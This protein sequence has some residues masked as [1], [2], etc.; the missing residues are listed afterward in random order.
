MDD[1]RLLQA[2][3]LDD[4][5]RVVRV[6]AAHPSGTTELVS[7]A[8]RG[9]H[10]RKRIP[11][12]L[13]NRQAWEALGKVRDQR[14]PRVEL[15]YELPDALVVVCQYVVGTTVA[16]LLSRQTRL[17]AHEAAG[18]ALGVC[19]AASALHAQG[20]VHRDIAPGNVVIAPNILGDS[21]SNRTYLI[22]LG[23]A[24]VRSDDVAAH[25]TTTLG[26]RGFSAPEQ[27]GF[28]QTDARSDVYSIGRLLLCLLLGRTSDEVSLD[29]AALSHDAVPARLRPIIERACAFEPSA[30]YQSAADMA[31][32]LE[33]AEVALG[34]T[35]VSQGGGGYRVA[36]PALGV[37]DVARRSN[38]SSSVG[39]AD[40]GLWSRLGYAQAWAT[41]GL[42]R[43]SLG[44]AS[45]V[46]ALCLGLTF[47]SAAFDSSK[48]TRPTDPAYFLAA[49]LIG[50]ACS[51]IA[52]NELCLFFLRGGRY[53]DVPN[54][55]KL[56][57]RVLLIDAAAMVLLMMLAAMISGV[58]DGLIKNFTAG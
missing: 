25:D 27:Y 3:E 30:R 42:I 13:A 56:L 40:A 37:E 14:V 49:G 11:H 43:Q 33:E 34:G 36:M 55:K 51:L 24:R 32:D 17:E 16:E 15:I 54:R 19:R 4:S 48:F 28:A 47:V 8:N 46:V 2:L 6:L 29:I 10:I 18:I 57:A 50:L 21:P 9:L 31:A 7:D 38:A 53:R 5:Y 1:Q 39:E 52:G 22:D 41:A 44:V 45:W 12:E 58:V 35:Y 26:T 23:V 20:I